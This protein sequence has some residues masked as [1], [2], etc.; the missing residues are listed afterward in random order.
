MYSP[1]D[2]SCRIAFP[3]RPAMSG[4]PSSTELTAMR[5]PLLRTLFTGVVLVLTY[6]VIELLSFAAYRSLTGEFYS[7]STVHATQLARKEVGQNFE[8]SQAPR[9]EAEEV[10]ALLAAQGRVL[11]LHPYLGFVVAAA[12]KKTIPTRGVPNLH[13]TEFGFLDTQ[14]PI[15]RRS[16]DR[17]IVGVVGG[18]VANLFTQG[19]HNVLERELRKSPHFADREFV[20]VRI[21]LGGYKQPQQL[22]TVAYLLSLG[23]EFDI[24][25]NIDGFNE[26]ALYPAEHGLGGLPISYPRQWGRRVADVADPELQR[27]IGELAYLEGERWRLAATASESRLRFS[28][29]RNL[30]WLVADSRLDNRIF[31]VSEAL[32]TYEAGLEVGVMMGRTVNYAGD[33]ELFSALADLWAQ[34]SRQL[35]RLVRSNGGLYLHFL[36]PN[37]YLEGSKPMSAR[38]R[39]HAIRDQAPYRRGVV[40]GYPRLLD[41]GRE[42]EASGIRFV[43]LTQIFSEVEEPV[44]IDTCCHLNQVGNAI[45]ADHIARAVLDALPEGLPGASSR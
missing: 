32:L 30:L 8:K 3:V 7:L 29:L 10:A 38:E 13:V 21:A 44:Y 23:A 9:S 36:Q 26:V 33:V 41:R 14:S 31:E 19:G 45:M 6:V 24:V 35:D 16:D 4:R 2:G 27:M 34:S 37:Q 17:V 1:P 11:R 28:V 25:I 39:A 40:F 22:L 20:F 5:R 43:D 42:L 18:S 15:H 12:E